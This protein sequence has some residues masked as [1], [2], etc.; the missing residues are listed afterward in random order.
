MTELHFGETAFRSMQRPTSSAIAKNFFAAEN[1]K[2]DI[3]VSGQ[4][5][6]VCQ[7]LLAKAVELAIAR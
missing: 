6:S 5:A 7:Q 1:L 2:I 3:V 4:S